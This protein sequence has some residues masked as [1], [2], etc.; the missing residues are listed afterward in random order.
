MTQAF[1]LKIKNSTRKIILL[2]LADHANDDGF[3]WPSYQHLAD[4][5]E[6]NK[7]TVMTHM[8]AM[9]E[10]GLLS[11]QHRMS[12][13]GNS[14]NLYQ[15]T[16]D[17]YK[18]KITRKHS[19]PNHNTLPPKEVPKPVKSRGAKI[20]PHSDLRSLDGDP[21]SPR[22]INETSIDKK[23][24]DLVENEFDHL[25]KSWPNT[26]AKKESLKAW[27]KLCKNNPKQ[28]PEFIRNSLVQDIEKRIA[29]K[30]FAFTKT[31][32]SSYLNGE[33]WLDGHNEDGD[34][35]KDPLLEA[36]GLA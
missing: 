10:L 17:N 23:D 3:C 9:Q 4:I 15:L 22:I 24:K 14:S 19:T 26:K 12:N 20:S 34:T 5:C 8:K 11:I 7:R 6:C 32:L 33:R 29:N 35:R 30:Q 13:K 16:L 31:M 2:K 27:R 36:M 28:K 25:W 21:R 1:N 18:D